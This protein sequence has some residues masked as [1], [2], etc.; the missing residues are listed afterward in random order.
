MREAALD[1]RR[2]LE[3]VLDGIV[4]IDGAAR[5]ELLN[6]EACR[7]LEISEEAALGA[8]L[9]RIATTRGALE[10]LARGVLGSGRACI[11]SDHRVQSRFGEPMLI[12]VAVSPLL[13]EDQRTRGAVLV[14]RDRTIA[15]SLEEQLS[16][17]ERLSAFGHMASGIAHEVKNPLG[18]IRGAAEILASRAT[19]AKMRDA[20]EVIVREVARITA[21]VDELMIFARGEEIR[22]AATNIHRV[23]E[24]V[25]QL[26]AHDALAQGVRIERRFDPSLPEL[27]AD[28]DRLVQV[29]L[30]LA[31]NALQA[32]NGTGTLTVETRM[33]LDHRLALEP[34]A[35]AGTLV[36]MLA[37]D[38]PGMAPD[39][40]DWLAT[41]F[42]TTRP[43]GVGL[44]L[45][46][47]RH[48]VTRHGGTLRVE[49][50]P[51][52]GTRVRVTLPLGRDGRAAME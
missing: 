42:F 15:R 11:E 41:P 10:T 37:D 47:S 22:F 31:R 38:G 18:G 34:G 35:S 32:L 21:L 48:W 36:V 6:A 26:L 25:L 1:L 43:D 28:A 50:A 23:L 40:L 14:L 12:D 51:N 5:I 3:A 49:S 27:H 16:E 17:R 7:I 9:A 45:A 30:N 2:V 20:A 46:V 39:V 8:P 52:R 44:G 29:F 24:N 4:V 13:E 19:D 33:A